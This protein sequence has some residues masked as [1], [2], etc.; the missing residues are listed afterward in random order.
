MDF[1]PELEP[2]RKMCRDGIRLCNHSSLSLKVRDNS[3]S[4]NSMAAQRSALLV[5]PCHDNASHQ[6]CVLSLR[7]IGY[8]C[9]LDTGLTVDVLG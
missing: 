5:N 2:T 7:G 3:K 6:I 8:F 1:G 9:F 4:N